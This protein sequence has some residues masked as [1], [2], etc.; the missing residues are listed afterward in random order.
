M[1]TPF[2]HALTRD[3]AVIEKWCKSARA[4]QI[5]E[6]PFPVLS[7]LNVSEGKRD[8]KKSPRCSK[9]DNA[10][11]LVLEQKRFE[12]ACVCAPA[13]KQAG[14]CLVVGPGV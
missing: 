2:E 5:P 9:T 1:S 6:E 3:L 7:L 4:Q 8:N 14:C 12:M 11:D 13:R 10:K